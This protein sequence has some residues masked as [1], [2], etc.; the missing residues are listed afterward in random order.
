MM[1]TI[2]SLPVD[3]VSTITGNMSQIIT[4]LSPIWLLVMSILL[5][6]LVITFL[7]RVLHRYNMKKFFISGFFILAGV[8]FFNNAF[9]TVIAQ[10]TET[11]ATI[12]FFR[13]DAPTQIL[14]QSFT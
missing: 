9:A 2:I 12:Y 14:S 7:I 13:Y 3:A 6:V 1:M 8:L 4:D 11:G 5:A 10:Q